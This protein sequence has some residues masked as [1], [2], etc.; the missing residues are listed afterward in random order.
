MKKSIRFLDKSCYDAETKTLKSVR[1]GVQEYMGAEIGMSPAYKVFKIFRSDGTIRAIND[2]MKNLPI[3]NDHIDVSGTVPAEDIQGHVTRS[4]V[5]DFVDA[6]RACTIAIENG[7]A[8]SDSV[9]GFI[10][11]G[12]NQL[13]LGYNA[14]L[15]EH[16][17]YDFEQVDI[18]P[19]HLAIVERGRCGDVCTFN[20]K[21]GSDSMKIKDADGKPNL[22][23][24]VEIAMALPEAMKT[25][26]VDE[27]QTV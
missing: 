5:I 27:L 18:I 3:T 4:K 7:V 13:S 17:K 6:D 14:Q 21:I 12:K 2:S 22:Q 25:V 15:I 19:H 23:R 8:L 9:L 10:K 11:A 16:S 24:I 26:P 1:D 20:D